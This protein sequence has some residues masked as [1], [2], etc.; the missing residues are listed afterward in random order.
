[1]IDAVASL[2]LANESFYEAF[3]AGNLDA[4]KR[5]WAREAPVACAH[6]GA[7]VLLG[8]DAVMASWTAAL[9]GGGAEGFHC[10]R[11]RA[12][13]FGNAGFVTCFERLG[14]G[15]LLATNVFVLEDDEWRMVHHHASPIAQSR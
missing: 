14:E 4:M 12:A 13:L 10:E 5:L 3:A 9:S 2:L 15:R 6:P 7:D 1:M 8:R 11:P